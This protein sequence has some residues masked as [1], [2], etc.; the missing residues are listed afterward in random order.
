MNRLLKFHP[1]VCPVGKNYQIMINTWCDALVSVKVGDKVYYNHS[2]G[3]RISSK[4]VH[5]F[6]VPMCELD[7]EEL[8]TVT[9]LPMIERLPYYPRTGE[10]VESN[11]SFRPIKKTED[12]KIYH[13][14]DV[15]GW[16]DYAVWASEYFNEQYD[17]L[18]LNGD[19][20]STSNTFEDMI[21]CYKIASD[22]TKG[23]LPCII[24]RGNHDLR[25][26]GAENLT[27]YM[28]TDNGN[29][30][31][32]FKVGCIWGILVDTGEDKDDLSEEYGG[33]VCCHEFRLEQEEMIKKV[34]ENASSEYEND[35]V[36]YKLVISHIPFTFKRE[37]KLDIE[38]ELYSNWA[39]LLKDNVKP[40]LMLSGHTHDFCISEEGSKFDDL[41]HP[42]TVVVGSYVNPDRSDLSNVLA[43][44]FIT[45]NS[46]S[47]DVKFNTKRKII[48][49]GKIK[50]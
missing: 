4:G 37:G 49:E 17:L 25:G 30:Y 14:A 47:A 27:N 32:T 2:N 22:I 3:I 43:G 21:L 12:I 18:I 40:N 42:C 34:I 36:K 45:L 48:G 15:H 13:L 10:K 19:I 23:E 28:P 33:T 35:A 29:S 1:A 20:S 8:Y 41:G 39:N 26:Y 31:Y 50:F 46:D 44:A 6:T 38:R 16:A 9:I 5:K 24:S 11:Y 7:R